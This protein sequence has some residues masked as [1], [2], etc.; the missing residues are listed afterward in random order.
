MKKT[1]LLTILTA[2]LVTSLAAPALAL[3][4]CCKKNH[5]EISKKLDLSDSQLDKW[6][7]IKQAK[8]AEMMMVDDKYTPQ[9]K[10]VLNTDQLAKFEKMKDKKHKKRKGC[11]V[12]K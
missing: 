12:K 10:A 6:V 8:K 3:K 9:L 4:D 1:I 5:K 7:A 2:C 11:C